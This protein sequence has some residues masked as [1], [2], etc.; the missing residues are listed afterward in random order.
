[1]TRAVL[2]RKT[3]TELLQLAKRAGLRGISLLK[4]AALIEALLRTAAAPTL[5]RHAKKKRATSRKS[6]AAA[7]PKTAKKEVTPKVKDK[8]NPAAKKTSPAPA[9]ATTP[10]PKPVLP[11]AKPVTPPARPK[12]SPKPASVTKTVP[13]TKA[14]PVS[15]PVPSQPVAAPTSPVTAKKKAPRLT[16]LPN[17][18][19]K[20]GLV[21]MEIDP[22]R[23]HIYWEVT[24]ADRESALK[25]LGKE[26][27]GSSWILRFY[28]TTYIQFDGKNAHSHF[29]VPIDLGTGNWYIELWSGEKTYC[30][31]IGAR[32]VTGKFLPVARSNFVQIPRAEQS[33]EYRP[34]WTKVEHPAGEV[35]PPAPVATAKA[36][37]PVT[38]PASASPVQ[39][40][41]ITATPPTT[42]EPKEITEAK[43]R[44]HYQDMVS[45]AVEV[46]SHPPSVSERG[47]GERQVAGQV[48][49]I[50]PMPGSQQGPVGAAPSSA[51]SSSFGLGGSGGAGFPVAKPSI[52]LHLNTEIVVSG[53]AQPGQTV[54]LNGHWIKVNA[55]GTFSVRLALPVAQD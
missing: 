15:Q 38:L 11:A 50:V 5:R 13:V 24:A 31:E 17:E 41:T 1:M 39:S 47:T 23:L 3:R 9:A 4:K 46:P 33:P 35:R 49:E 7:K 51:A 43:V 55:D 44:R 8:R 19:G 52:D 36:I 53:R 20:T 28:D 18:Y 48:A 34:E 21:V 14:V 45:A 32:S 42:E 16:E 30:A 29:D 6:V 54:Q 2:E 10:A 37:T 25:K 26:G 40:E 12:P 27:A 22:R